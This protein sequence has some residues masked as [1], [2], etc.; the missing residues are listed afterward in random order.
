MTGARTPG[1][2]CCR[3][4]RGEMRRGITLLTVNSS[5]HR[6]PPL[7]GV[8]CPRYLATG[9]AARWAVSVAYY[10]YIGL[11]RPGSTGDY[12]FR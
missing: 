11:N 9:R 4:F 3:L 8:A 5:T 6:T 1:H 12:I 2:H 7:V 10:S